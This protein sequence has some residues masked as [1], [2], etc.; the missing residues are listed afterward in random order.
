MSW[1]DNFFKGLIVLVVSV[2]VTILVMGGLSEP[3]GI[4]MILNPIENL[5]GEAAVLAI[6]QSLWTQ[7]I[8]FVGVLLAFGWWFFGSEAKKNSQTPCTQ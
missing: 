5:F 3:T 1:I 7:G 2:F 4:G 6:Q 8:V